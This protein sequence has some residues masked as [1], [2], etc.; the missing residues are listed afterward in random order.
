MSYWE[1]WDNFNKVKEN[2]DDTKN[3]ILNLIEFLNNK[4]EIEREYAN[5]LLKLTKSSLFNR[6]KNTM[7][8]CLKR[9]QTICSQQYISLQELISHQQTDI[10]YSLKDLLIKQD[11]IIKTKARYAKDFDYELQRQTLSCEKTKDI[12]YNSCSSNDISTKKQVSAERNYKKTIENANKFLIAFENNMKPIFFLY[13]KHEEDKISAI[14]D[15]LRRLIVYEVSYFRSTQYEKDLF[16]AAI[17]ALNP[18]I[19]I[20]KFID[21]NASGKK[22]GKFVFETYSKRKNTDVQT[23]TSDNEKMYIENIDLVIEKSWNGISID[24]EDNQNF[25][26]AINCCEGRKYW[27]KVL[28]DKRLED[29]LC[30]PS[31]TFGII[32]SLFTVFLDKV[33]EFNDLNCMKQII[34]L[35]QYFYEQ[36]VNQKTFVYQ[37]IMTHVLWGDYILWG[38]LI[39]S[40]VDIEM[41]SD[42]K[43][44]SEDINSINQALKLRPVVYSKVSSYIQNMNKFI[45]DA[46]IIEKTIKLVQEHYALNIEL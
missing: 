14:K 23:N 25:Q 45:V 46:Q 26:N 11:E 40:S 4:T 37:M 41:E 39:I 7:I 16:P 42:A 34:F 6:G 31:C 18:E 35:T 30:I 21:D 5:G 12:F 44:C 32:C 29:K 13:Q 19:E 24:D 10:V 28:N 43:I 17:E 36:K 3:L 8:P 22:F 15:M 1:L 27:I 9:L 38:N 2:T 20:K 33:N